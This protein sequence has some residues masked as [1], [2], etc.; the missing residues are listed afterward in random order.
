MIRGSA[1]AMMALGVVHLAALGIDASA[2]APGWAAFALWST[3]HLLP[4]ADQ[5]PA[6][7]ASNAA[8][9]M[10]AGSMAIPAFLLGYLIFRLDQRGISIPVEIGWVFLIWQIGCALIMQPSGFI[11]S[12]AIAIVLVVGLHR[13]RRRAARAP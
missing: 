1:L 3:E 7:M 4:L 11:A 2:Y 5:S 13:Q 12:V 10:T 9:W 8:F 6:M